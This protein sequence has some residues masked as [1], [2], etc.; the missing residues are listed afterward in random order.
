MKTIGQTRTES[1]LSS[2]PDNITKLRAHYALLIDYME[3]E[4]NYDK[5][6]GEK[7]RL[8]SIAQE[9]LEEACMFAVKA[10]YTA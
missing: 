2:E 3:K 5:A 9:K 4:K 7:K 1:R 10:L 6:S 8:C